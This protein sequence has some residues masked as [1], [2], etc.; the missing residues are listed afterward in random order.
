MLFTVY[1]CI[2]N[3]NIILNSMIIYL[4]LKILCFKPQAKVKWFQ[5]KMIAFRA[6][7]ASLRVSDV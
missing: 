6:N 2:I 4:D 1:N 3:V 7:A 5:Q